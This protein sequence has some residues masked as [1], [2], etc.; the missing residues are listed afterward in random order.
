M[1]KDIYFMATGGA[2]QIG[3][4]CYFLKLGSSNILLDCG[5]STEGGSFSG[6]YFLDL[7]KSPLLESLDLIDQ[8]YISHAHLDHIGYLPSLFKELNSDTEIYMTDMTKKLAQFQ[9]FKDAGLSNSGRL[10]DGKRDLLLTD[11]FDRT[12]C[13][14]FGKVMNFK[15]HKAGFFKAGHIPGAAMIGFRYGGRNILYTGDYSFHNTLLTDGMCLPDNFPVDIMIMCG[16]HAKH[17]EIK[18]NNMMLNESFA[19]II[20]YLK[21][22]FSV[23]CRAAQLTKGAETAKALRKILK[24]YHIPFDIYIDD[25]IMNIVEKM[26]EAGV[27]FME[28]GIK[29]LNQQWDNNP[30]VII[31]GKDRK[32]EFPSCKQVKADFSLHDDFKEMKEFIKRVNPKTAVIVHTAPSSGYSGITIK[33]A[34]IRDADSRTDFIF[35]ECGEYFRL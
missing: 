26:E 32:H 20:D 8:V 23:Y 28:N 12:V 9:F 29:S 31:C 18:R 34:L 30:R 24:R 19:R 33:D 35:P 17:P 13:A 25:T 1:A 6:P 15:N 2:Q 10:S 27:I 4:S 3:A 21:M 14:S 22:G 16:T 7:L 5:C 11:M